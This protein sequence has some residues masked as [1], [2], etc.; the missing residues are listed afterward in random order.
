M[1][2]SYCSYLVVEAKVNIASHGATELTKFLSIAFLRASVRDILVAAKG[3]AMDLH[4]TIAQ[5]LVLY[6]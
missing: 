1:M 6:A 4:N 2:F 3:R 5:V